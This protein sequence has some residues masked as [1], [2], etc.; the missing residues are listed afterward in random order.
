MMIAII[1]S[2]EIRIFLAIM[3]Y[4]LPEIDPQPM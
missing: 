3:A 1:D 2:I 4:M